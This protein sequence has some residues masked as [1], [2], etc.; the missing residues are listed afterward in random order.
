MAVME[1]KTTPEPDLNL[2]VMP[3]KMF[4]MTLSEHWNEQSQNEGVNEVIA[5]TTILMI[6][7]TTM[8]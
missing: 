4:V 6:D 8:T 1:H 5:T 3:W 7:S 2:F